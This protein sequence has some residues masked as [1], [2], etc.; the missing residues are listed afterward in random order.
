LPL[1]V[2]SRGSYRRFEDL[3]VWQRAHTL[4]GSIYRFTS[5]GTLAKDFDRRDQMRA[6]A[7]SVASNIAEGFEHGTDKQFIQ[8]LFNSRGSC[9]ELRTRLYIAID[10]HGATEYGAVELIAEAEEVSRVLYGLITS[11]EPQ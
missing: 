1:V 4:A 8:F 9:G 5:D 10:N 3:K 11:L 7:V 2:S 6:A